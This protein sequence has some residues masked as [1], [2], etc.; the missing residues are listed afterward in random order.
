MRQDPA[1][2]DY[3]A[4]LQQMKNT[5]A[6]EAMLQEGINPAGKKVPDISGLLPKPVV[7]VKVKV[8]KH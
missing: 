3:Y 4:R 5:A 1:K 8:G 2:V 6:E 7:K